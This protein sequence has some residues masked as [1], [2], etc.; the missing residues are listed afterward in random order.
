[1]KRRAILA[2]APLV[3]IPGLAL[4]ADAV[5]SIPLS[6]RVAREKG[7][8]DKETP[9][10]DKDFIDELISEAK[11]IY[12]EHQLSFVDTGRGELPASRAM[13][14]TRADR[15]AMVE[16]MDTGVANVFLVRSLRDVDDPKLYRM[17]VMWRCLKN[18]K[19]K[20]V[21]VA[22]SARPTTLAH[23]LGH[24]LGL[25]HSSVKNN[26]MSYEREPG[27][28]I[29]LDERQGDKC[30]KTARGLFA[31]KELVEKA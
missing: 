21:I 11:S 28:K 2:C 10:V 29:F 5:P 6:I 17:G 24:F 7:D 1:M 15:D 18:L 3:A 30:R 13:L 22:A 12:A 23:E 20:Y 31:K 8:S 27:A 25:D 19:K 9:V 26:L 16:H 14:E 4:A